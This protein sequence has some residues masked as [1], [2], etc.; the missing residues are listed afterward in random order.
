MD[1]LN[2]IKL[3]TPDGRDKSFGFGAK[4]PTILTLSQIQQIAADDFLNIVTQT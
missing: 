4:F 1:R 3:P 2:R